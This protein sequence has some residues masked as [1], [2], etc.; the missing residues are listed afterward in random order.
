MCQMGR[1]ALIFVCKRPAYP[2]T[3][4]IS[5]F[6]NNIML[7]IARKVEGIKIVCEFVAICSLVM[8]L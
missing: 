5:A 3:V 8:T 6:K 7:S 4:I 2:I 1:K